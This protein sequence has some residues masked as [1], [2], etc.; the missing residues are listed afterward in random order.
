MSYLVEEISSCLPQHSLSQNDHPID[1]RKHTLGKKTLKNVLY[2][3]VFLAFCILWVATS[4]C[5]SKHD[6]MCM[7]HNTTLLILSLVA[8]S[9]CDREMSTIRVCQKRCLEPIEALTARVYILYKYKIITQHHDIH[10]DT[11]TFTA[12]G[13]GVFTLYFVGYTKICFHP[14]GV[15]AACY[16]K[17][18]KWSKVTMI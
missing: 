8:T 1:P 4:Y 3:D 10:Q 11:S 17:V 7:T 12:K 13:Y 5:Y 6:S 14:S 15:L 18:L 2:V 9:Q 16:Q